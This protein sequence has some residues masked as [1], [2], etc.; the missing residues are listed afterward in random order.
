[1]EFSSRRTGQCGPLRIS[2]P[3]PG[4]GARPQNQPQGQQP[5]QCSSCQIK[6]SHWYS[7]GRGPLVSFVFHMVL[8]Q[9]A[10]RAVSHRKRAAPS[11][12]SLPGPV[13]PLRMELDGGHRQAAVLHRLCHSALAPGGAAEAI[14]QTVHRLVVG[15]VDQGCGCPTACGAG[16]PARYK[17]DATGRAPLMEGAQRI[18]Q[19]LDQGCRP[20][21]HSAPGAPADPKDGPPGRQIGPDQSQ[22]RPV[23]VQIRRPGTPVRRAVPRGGQI[24]P[25]AQQQSA[26]GQVRPGAAAHHRLAARPAGPLPHTAPSALGPRRSGCVLPPLRLLPPARR[27]DQSSAPSCI[28]RMRTRAAI[29]STAP[30]NAGDTG[31]QGQIVPAHLSPVVSC[32]VVVVVGSAPVDL[33]DPL[34]HI[35]RGDMVFLHAA[36]HLVLQ[37]SVNEYLQALRPLPQNI[38]AAPPYDDAGALVRQLP[39]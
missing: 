15:A 9:P 29:S 38:V 12:V 35:L 5:G 8:S 34:Y 37:R 17:W 14:A 10:A 7:P 16:C 1:M 20:G 26:A 36:G 3:P 27:G 24:A 23:P 33:P 21:P 31:I 30:L 32:V 39:G 11:A 22:L 25:T 6:S 13:Q 4:H 28:P 19:I 18:P 2:L